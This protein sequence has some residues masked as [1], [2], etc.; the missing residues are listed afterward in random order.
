ML[1]RAQRNNNPG[2]IRT[3]AGGKLF[4]GQS[5][6]DTNAGGPFAKFGSPVSGFDALASLLLEY[7]LVHKLDTI[8]AIF[9]RYAPP[10]ENNTAAYKAMIAKAVGV[11]IGTVLDL[12]RFSVLLAMTTAIGRYEAGTQWWRALDQAA[13]I[14]AALRRIGVELPC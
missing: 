5:G 6:V 13:G 10:V 11:S 8:D 1:P 7:Q 12:R 2:N 14:N 9:N 3:L 4:P